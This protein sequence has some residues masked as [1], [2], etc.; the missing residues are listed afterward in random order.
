[1]SMD[2]IVWAA[3]ALSLPS[4]LPATEHWE[5]HGNTE[6]VYV[7]DD[8]QVVV[9]REPLLQPPDDVASTI[10]ADAAA[11]AVSIAPVSAGG[12]GFEFWA[13]VAEQIAVKCGGAMLH[14]PMGFVELNADGREV[15]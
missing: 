1:M 7:A 12:D 6:W 13:S 2:V 14:G 9:S 10:G 11:T 15:L 5:G 3:C 4:D 8:W